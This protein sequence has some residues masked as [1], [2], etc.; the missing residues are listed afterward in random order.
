MKPL[1]ITFH[2]A[3]AFCLLAAALLV[4]GWRGN[5]H[6]RQLNAQTQNIFD[7]QWKQEQ[8]SQ[9]AFHLSDL[10]SRIILL[11][12]LVD[13]QDEIKQL[14]VQRAANTQRI[15]DLAR[16]IE[17][18]LETEDEK[19]LFA[20]VK[21]TRTPYVESYQ[22]ALALLLTEQ[23]RDEARKMMVDI[24]R[25]N[26]IAYHNA[27]NNFDQYEADEIDQLIQKSKADYI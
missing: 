10:N 15:T 27:W 4:V 21:A 16:A 18:R 17:L 25:P 3:A 7:D 23:K 20:I 9:E 19:Q 12:F 24:V 13:D 11:V 2:L 8:L 22:R 14:L 26:L 1:N 5:S 6:L